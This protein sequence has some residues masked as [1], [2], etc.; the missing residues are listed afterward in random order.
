MNANFRRDTYTD[1]V[2]V[3]ETCFPG[4][5][6]TR[7]Q[8]LHGVTLLDSVTVDPLVFR[9]QVRHKWWLPK[10]VQEKV[11][12]HPAEFW[13]EKPILEEEAKAG[14]WSTNDV[15]VNDVTP[16][17]PEETVLQDHGWTV[18][19]LL[20][21]PGVLGVAYE[22]ALKDEVFMGYIKEILDIVG[23]P[24]GVFDVGWPC[25]MILATRV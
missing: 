6:L 13:A 23:G 4:S 14:L 11:D 21:Y 16:E 25:S 10:T 1:D 17:T 18:A 20:Q 19:T 3:Y 22:P 2:L 12:R 5:V 24:E 15:E 7:D 9:Y 8:I